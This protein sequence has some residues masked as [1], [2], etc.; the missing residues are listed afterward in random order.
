MGPP[1]NTISVDVLYVALGTA[2]ITNKGSVSCATGST[3]HEGA[4]GKL[5][6]RTVLVSNA[7][8]LSHSFP[9]NT[10]G[11]VGSARVP[12]PLAKN[13]RTVP[14]MSVGKPLD[15]RSG[16]CVLLACIGRESTDLVKPTLPSLSTNT[17]STNGCQNDPV[18][19]CG[20]LHCKALVTAAHDNMVRSGNVPP[21]PSGCNMKRSWN[22]VAGV[23][24]Q[25]TPPT[26]ALAGTEAARLDIDNG[27]KKINHRPTDGNLPLKCSVAVVTCGA[28]VAVLMLMLELEKNDNVSEGNDHSIG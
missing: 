24:N 9:L 26:F 21:T 18:R 5:E 8:T 13:L 1:T 7:L 23:L 25:V 3:L 10:N 14:G 6:H 27:A 22:L 12:W 20:S 2:V 15:K 17:Q 11:L 19:F 28:M 16:L 4:A